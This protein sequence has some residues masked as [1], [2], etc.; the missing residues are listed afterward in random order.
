MGRVDKEQRCYR[1]NHTKVSYAYHISRSNCSDSCSI[2]SDVNL[3]WN[4]CART[5]AKWLKLNER[6]CALNS[7]RRDKRSS[8]S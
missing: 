3:F 4:E 8:N 6:R 7:Y 1:D 2:E 5:H